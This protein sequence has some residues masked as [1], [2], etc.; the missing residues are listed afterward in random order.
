[1]RGCRSARPSPF[2]FSCPLPLAKLYRPVQ[3]I[4]HVHERRPA[5]DA[6]ADA[7]GPW[8]RGAR[9]RALPRRRSAGLRAPVDRA[10][11]VGRGRVLAA[12]P[13]GR[14]H[15][16]ASRPRSLPREGPRPARDVRR[17]DGQGPGTNRGRGG[18]MHIADPTIGIFGANGIVGAGLPIA[19]G[20]ATAAQLDTTA[21]SRSRSSATARWRT[22]PST[23]RST[24]P[25]FGGCR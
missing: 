2:P 23:K 5:R 1:M 16:H 13:E 12:R 7:H 21:V 10:G 11:G 8:I 4:A 6:Q 22:A 19:A 9:R 20:A 17:V 25:R 15:V 14:D 3:Y 24:S 18:S